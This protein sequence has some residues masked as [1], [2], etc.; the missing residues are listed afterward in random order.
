[1][2]INK[3]FQMQ[4]ALDEYIK[5]EHK[6]A[7]ENLLERKILAFLVELGELANETRCFKFWSVKPS[8]E[9]NIVLEEYVDGLHFLL[10][11]GIELGF[12]DIEFDIEDHS[13]LSSIS[14]QFLEIYYATVE[15]RLIRNEQQFK[16]LFSLFLQLGKMLGFTFIEI[17]QAYFQ[18]NDVNYQRQQNGY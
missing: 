8:S 13:D 1:M 9:K 11:I 2:N 3:L 17:E 14:S 5:S 18:K 10:S 16:G 7:T 6:L 4:K 15:F 12:Q